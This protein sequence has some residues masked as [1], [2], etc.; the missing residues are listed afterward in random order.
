M[1][2]SF[3][4]ENGSSRSLASSGSQ[5]DCLI[6]ATPEFNSGQLDSRKRWIHFLFGLAVILIAGASIY[7]AY[8]VYK[9]REGVVERNP[10]CDW[11]IRQEP[12]SVSLF[13]VAK[14]TGTAGVVSVLIGLYAFWR[15]AG[16]TAAISLVMFQAGLMVYLHTSEVSRPPVVNSIASLSTISGSIQPIEETRNVNQREK[17][18]RANPN[19]ESRP[20]KRTAKQGRIRAQAKRAK[21]ENKKSSKSEKSNRRGTIALMSSEVEIH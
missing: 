7:D 8:L 14:G 2:A 21:Q 5:M 12:D 20:K 9:Y 1:P 3:R 17:Q 19:R 4:I 11:L 15:R 10:I 13:L 16:V 18:K 6:P